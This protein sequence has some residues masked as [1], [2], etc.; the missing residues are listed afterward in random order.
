[1]L[2]GALS[3]YL[4]EQLTRLGTWIPSFARAAELLEV[5]TGVCVSAAG[6]RRQT[7]EA[8]AMY[9]QHQEAEVARLK[10]AGGVEPQGPEQLVISADGATIPLV[11]GKWAEVKTLVIGEPRVVT[12]RNGERVVKTEKQSYFSR[13]L[14]VEAFKWQALVETHRRGVA[15][16]GKVGCLADGAEWIQGFADFHCPDALRILDMP[17]AGEYVYAMGQA[18]Y[19]EGTPEALAWWQQQ[20]QT[21]KTQGAGAVLPTLETLTQAH[22]QLPILEEKL[23]YLSKREDQMQY[24]TYEA[25]GWPLGS[26]IVE[27]ANKLV[28]EERLKGSGM[29]WAPGHVNPLLGLRNIVFNDRWDEAWLQITGDLRQQTWQRR[30][31]RPCAHHAAQVPEEKRTAPPH[32]EERVS[33]PMAPTSQPAP[34]GPAPVP[35]TPTTATAPQ[36]HRPAPNHPWRHSPIGKARFEPRK[37]GH[38]PKL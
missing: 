14:E 6:M 18:L 29:R 34:A 4:R 33:I 8:G 22:P 28:V 9:V 13:V 15:T 26:G 38:P 20:M 7:E 10:E 24:P 16:A 23:A 19:G 2:E 21:L 17:H 36:P 30:L 5:F 27:S 31:A 32:T 25:E 1:L 11:G 12:G 37:A 35:L 3:P